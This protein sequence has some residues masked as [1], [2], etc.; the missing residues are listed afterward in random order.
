MEHETKGKKKD[1]TS[2]KAGI[3]TIFSNRLECS[4]REKKE[5]RNIKSHA[6]SPITKTHRAGLEKMN[7][8]MR[9]MY[10]YAWNKTFSGSGGC[11]KT[12]SS[13]HRWP[14]SS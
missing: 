13:L 5:K 2:P 8:D 12:K 6:G 7:S 10:L 14:A 4:F 1:R 9:I 3:Y 11:E